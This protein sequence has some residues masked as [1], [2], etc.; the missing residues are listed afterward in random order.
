MENGYSICLNEWALDKTIKNELGL[1]LIISSLCA[2]KGYCYASNKFFTELF[3]IDETNISKKI[4]KLEEKGYI[5]IEYSKNGSA[6]YLRK[7]RLVKIP[8]AVGKNTNG[9]IIINNNIKNNISKNNNSDK[10]RFQKPTKTEIETY[11]KENNLT[12]DADY[13]IDYYESKGWLVGKSPMKNWKSA[14]RN[15]CRNNYKY[16]SNNTTSSNKFEWVTKDG[17]TYLERVKQ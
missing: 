11:A 8:M 17:E 6:T 9:D 16:P 1:L 10:K 4:K 13:F 12:I 5:A 2:E 15:W 3:D 7:I 14:I